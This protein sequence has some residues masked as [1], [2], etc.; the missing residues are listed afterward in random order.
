MSRYGRFPLIA[1]E[2]SINALK[3]LNTNKN[4]LIVS[5]ANNHMLDAGPQYVNFIIKTIGKIKSPN[6]RSTPKVI[7][8]CNGCTKIKSI[9]GKDGCKDMVVNNELLY[10]IV[11]VKGVKIGIIG[12]SEW[13]PRFVNE[14]MVNDR[15]KLKSNKVPSI[16]YGHGKDTF[17]FN[18]LKK[19]IRKL[20]GNVK[21][22]IPYVHFRKE[23]DQ[24]TPD[25][26]LN[27]AKLV[28][29]NGIDL[30]VG[31][32]P[33]VIHKLTL[34]NKNPCFIFDS[35]VKESVFGNRIKKQIDRL[36][37][38]GKKIVNIKKRT[39]SSRILHLNMNI[40]NDEINWQYRYTD[41]SIN[42]T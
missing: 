34:V 20:K 25:V 42:D 23:Y 28:T 37:S 13:F 1:E 26:N 33:H 40:V 29:S 14:N 19:I 22:I 11:N 12:L 21:S 36:K 32:G 27:I 10:Q 31:S 17:N 6:K 9:N 4:K 30:I 39:H 3:R 7:G 8:V 2:K 15:N 38:K 24:I 16:M 18:L 41:C 35:H 5:M